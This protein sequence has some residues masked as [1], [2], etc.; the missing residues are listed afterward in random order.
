LNP[1]IFPLDFEVKGAEDTTKNVQQKLKE[2]SS[3]MAK[4]NQV[5][6][7]FHGDILDSKWSYVRVL[8][9]P[10]IAYWEDWESQSHTSR[11][12]VC[13]YCRHFILDV[14]KQNDLHAW[15]QTLTA[16]QNDFPVDHQYENLRIRILGFLLVAESE[17]PMTSLPLEQREQMSRELNEKAMVGRLFGLTSEHPIPNDRALIKRNLS[18]AFR[19][20]KLYLSGIQTIINWNSDNIELLGREKRLIMDSDFGCGKTLL[21]VAGAL[22]LCE[23]RKDVIFISTAAA[24]TQV[25]K[26]YLVTFVDIIIQYYEPA[27]GNNIFFFNFVPKM[28]NLFQIK[29]FPISITLHTVQLPRNLLEASYVEQWSVPQLQGDFF[30]LS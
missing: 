17:S 23:T 7:Q 4:R 24:R 26:K 10:L 18:T 12:Q 3:Q 9:L 28:K 5:L 1:L 8:V 14:S 30:I 29:R 2:A 13:D 25:W 6:K 15:L 20:N 27:T 22:R 16:R 11:L 21:L 19:E